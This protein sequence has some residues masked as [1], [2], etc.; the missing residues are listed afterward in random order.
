MNDIAA[1]KAELLSKYG[2]PKGLSR[3]AA[4]YRIGVSP[5]MFDQLVDDGRMP[6][7]KKINTKPVWDRDAV[8]LAFENLP[9]EDDSAS[10]WDKACGLPSKTG[11]G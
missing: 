5:S 10:Q 6:K 8:D 1:R 7:P 9:D 11:R 2:P 4:A 3:E